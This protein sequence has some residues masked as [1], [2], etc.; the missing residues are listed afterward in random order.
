MNSTIFL[1]FPIL[2]FNIT[3][4]SIIEKITYKKKNEVLYKVFL[5]WE[6]LIEV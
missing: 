5:G 4:F 2:N 1:Y 6:K 3:F